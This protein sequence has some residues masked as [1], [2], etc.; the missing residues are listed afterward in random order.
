MVELVCRLANKGIEIIEDSSRIRPDKSEV[1]R[2][3]A[4]SSKLIEATQWSPRVSLEEGLA[5]TIDWQKSHRDLSLAK[6]YQR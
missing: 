4:D 6:N 5:L 3:L 2:L 1:E